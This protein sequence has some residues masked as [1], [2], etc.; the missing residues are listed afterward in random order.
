MEE[1]TMRKIG[2]AAVAVL[3]LGLLALSCVTG[4]HAVAKPV[5]VDASRYDVRI[6][7]DTWGVP[8]IFGKKDTDVAFGLAYAHAEDDFITIQDVLL[9]TRGQLASI[10]GRKAAPNDYLVRLLRIWDLVNEKYETDLSPET[11][12]LCEASAEGFNYYA[13]LHPQNL[14]PGLLPVT[15][16]DVVAGF[17][18]KVPLFFNLNGALEELFEPTRTQTVSSRTHVAGFFS[19]FAR[20]SFGSNTFAVGPARSAD[21]KTRLAINSHQPW[22]GPVTWYEA[23]LHSEEGW[24]TV[25]GL[26][27]GSPMV[28]LGHNRKLGWASTVNW[29][30]LIDVYVLDINPKNQNQ[31]KF[32]GQWRD[33]EVRTEPIRVKLFGPFSI[34]VK[35]ELLWSVYG[36]TIR[37][38]HGTYAVRYAGMGNIRQVEQWHRLNKAQTFDEWADAMRIMSIPMFNFGYADC[39]GNIYYLYNALLPKRAEGYN[40]HEYLPGNTSEILWTEYLPFDRLPQIKNPASGF[41]QN[42]NSTPFQ[43]TT[44]PGNPKPEDYSPTCGI[45]TFMT[46]RALRALELFGGDESITA[47]EF[48]AYKFDIAYSKESEMARLVKEILDAPPSPDPVVREAV[49]VLSSWDLRTNAENTGTAIGVLSI[50]P[51]VRDERRGQP[52]PGLMRRFTRVAHELKRTHGRIDVPWAEVNRMHRGTLDAGLGGAPDV[53]HAVDGGNFQDGCV[54]GEAGDSYVLL[55]TWDK[56]GK[57]SS[58]SIHQ[59]GSATLDASSRHYADQAPLFINCKMKPVWMDESEIRAH[60]EH[61][62]RPG[63]EMAPAPVAKR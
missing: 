10:Y 46:N 59:Y 56:D 55:V 16:K 24:D 61:E 31:Y 25:G 60:L 17:A 63:E 11:R 7:R 8:H 44:G 45:E 18:Y 4:D 30:D 38:P 39:K 21:G 5:A 58:Q 51:V 15:G 20:E 37:R 34:N 14:K 32:D 62:Y 49:E 41:F 48:Y 23:H 19:P 42:C 33:L 36:P 12:A 35:R 6:L 3:V 43:T 2:A 53:L 13:S 29:P 40:W 50:A 1:S 57:V 47:E 27:P 9:A 28:L 26:F 52:I 54:T 22:A